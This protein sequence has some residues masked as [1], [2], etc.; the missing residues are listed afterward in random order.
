MNLVIDTGMGLHHWVAHRGVPVAFPGN[1]L[2][3]LQAALA[4]GAGFVEFDIQLTQD[5]VPILFHDATFYRAAN[6]LVKVADL[7]WEE[8]RSIPLS[9]VKGQ[10]I[11]IASLADAV[12]L[13]QG[14]PETI[15][16]VEIKTAAIRAGGEE[17]V[18]A[19]VLS[20]LA[21]IQSQSVLISF[22]MGILRRIQVLQGWPIGWVFATWSGRVRRRVE[23]LRPE[24]LFVDHAC[25][26]VGETL[27]TGS[28]R[29]VLYE[30]SDL[31]LA[32]SW[33]E[34]G[35]DLI[36]TNDLPRMIAHGLG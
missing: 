10:P 29:W 12:A 27:F 22:H 34:K 14:Y 3:S 35:A 18:M 5:G 36:E 26:P 24:Y 20:A 11:Y 4:V 21:P 19:A 31:A 1:S 28:W 17:K 25:I 23:Q 6:L 32:W 8:I 33:V 13:L 9:K 16:F 15:A 30:I 7:S 2:E